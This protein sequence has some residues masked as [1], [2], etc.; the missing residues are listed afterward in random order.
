M[1]SRANS[2][3]RFLKLLLKNYIFHLTLFPLPRAFSL[4]S[5]GTAANFPV[6]ACETLNFRLQKS[7][8]FLVRKILAQQLIAEI[9]L[10]GAI[11][12]IR[13]PEMDHWL[14][15]TVCILNPLEQKIFSSALSLKSHRFLNSTKETGDKGQQRE[16]WTWNHASGRTDSRSLLCKA[17]YMPDFLKYVAS[18]RTSAR[19]LAGSDC[20]YFKPESHELG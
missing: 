17:V 7:L 16:T 2:Q 18:N 4:R 6:A 10:Y 20:C 1:L 3:C 8:L 11:S 9:N 19:L 13:L 14:C 15:S 5:R 12:R